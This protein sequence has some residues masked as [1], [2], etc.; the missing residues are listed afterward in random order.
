MSLKKI[1]AFLSVSLVSVS[2]LWA[3]DSKKVYVDPLATENLEKVL[4]QKWDLVGNPYTGLIES[5]Y[6]GNEKDKKELFEKIN[7]F[8]ITTLLYDLDLYRLIS[9][10]RLNNSAALSDLE[11]CV[12]YYLNPLEFSQRNALTQEVQKRAEAENPT[13]MH[14]YG[15]LVLQKIL[16]TGNRESDI[17]LGKHLY[18][19]AAEKGNAKGY[20]ALGLCHYLGVFG[21]VNLQQATN[22]I[23]AAATLGLAAA[24]NWVGEQHYKK[25]SPLAV[26]YLLNAVQQQFPMAYYN[27][28]LCYFSGIGVPQDYT[29]AYEYFRMAADLKISYAFSKLGNIFQ[30]GLGQPINCENA[31]KAYQIGAT[32]GCMDSKAGLAECY[33]REFGTKQ[34]IEKG[35][36]LLRGLAS[37]DHP[38]GLFL[39]GKY[40]EDF[41]CK[42]TPEEN[43]AYVLNLYERAALN[44]TPFF[45]TT[46]GLLYKFG[47]G[48]KDAYKAEIH[49]EKALSTNDPSQYYHLAQG[50]LK[51]SKTT[52]EKNKVQ[53]F[54][55]FEE[56][57]KKGNK[58]AEKAIA[59]NF[60][61]EEMKKYRD[62]KFKRAHLDHFEA[63]SLFVKAN[64][65]F[66]K[67]DYDKAIDLFIQAENKGNEKATTFLQ[68]YRSGK[69]KDRQTQKVY[70]RVKKIVDKLDQRNEVERRKLGLSPKKTTITSSTTT[71]TPEKSS[72]NGRGRGRGRGKANS[73][74]TR[75]DAKANKKNKTKNEATTTTTTTSQDVI[76][77][78]NVEAQNEA[79]KVEEKKELANKIG[80]ESPA[81]DKPVE[82]KETT[83]AATLNQPE[84]QEGIQGTS[85]SSEEAKV[86]KKQ[87]PE[88]KSS[89]PT[90]AFDELDFSDCGSSASESES[91]LSEGY[92]LRKQRDTSLT[93][94]RSS[95]R[96]QDYTKESKAK[97]GGK[98][99]SLTRKASKVHLPNPKAPVSQG[100]DSAPVIPVPVSEQSSS[101]KKLERKM[102][103]TDLRN[104]M[105]VKLDANTIVTTLKD[106]KSRELISCRKSRIRNTLSAKSLYQK[107]VEKLTIHFTRKNG[108]E[109]WERD[110]VVTGFWTFVTKCDPELAKK[111][112][113]IGQKQAITSIEERQEKEAIVGGLTAF[114]T[115]HIAAL[116]KETKDTR[117][118]QTTA[119]GKEKD[120]R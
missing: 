12:I 44:E 5:A 98:T 92:H 34:D 11:L 77:N 31:F 99:I 49:L 25:N 46:L 28:G 60:S 4:E 47:L 33:L 100:M 38:T 105:D 27:L 43:N 94:T 41:P 13:M 119:H 56:S 117:K 3:M 69:C 71:D 16:S 6:R 113:S 81:N 48:V 101:N 37:E 72:R 107:D 85:G 42:P 91:E 106:L 65:S 35:L 14:L 30:L 21:V 80:A 23:E 102:S 61:I 116:T 111:V 32:L 120:K 24:Q 62:P 54:Y 20:Y 95:K 58:D 50:Y 57:A 90:S 8:T 89:S 93:A 96:H 40:C 53:A 88:M 36:I 59:Q 79:S 83:V 55:Y 104:V 19:K 73:G 9:Q 15:E 82:T 26:P 110:A 63:E 87:T 2:P 75:Q 18:L 74:P 86:E 68:Y 52:E 109:W 17:K 67:K 112:A 29:K 115:A 66:E 10:D 114:S 78:Q 39:L 108:E 70:D 118:T 103:K 97:R 7:N 64:L 22:N 76:A 45:N 51:Y 1:T 84:I